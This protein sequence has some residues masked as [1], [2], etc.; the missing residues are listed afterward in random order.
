VAA[1]VRHVRQLLAQRLAAIAPQDHHR[2]A[3]AKHLRDDTC[4]LPA[5]DGEA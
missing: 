5:E 4:L 3:A 2:V 1:G